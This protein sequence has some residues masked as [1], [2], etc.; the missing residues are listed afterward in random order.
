MQ[1]LKAAEAR[2]Q[3]DKIVQNDPI[4][5]SKF[6][7]DNT[8]SETTKNIYILLFAFPI[9]LLLSL[10]FYMIASLDG[11]MF[12]TPDGEIDTLIS[13]K[14]KDI[15]MQVDKETGG[16]LT[17]RVSDTFDK[18]ALGMKVV[19][20]MD[21]QIYLLQKMT[22]VGGPESNYNGFESNVN[23][24]WDALG[25]YSNYP[26]F[27]EWQSTS[28]MTFPVFKFNEENVPVGD[29]AK[30]CMGLSW[31]PI[32]KRNQ[33]DKYLDVKG[34]NEC[35]MHASGRANWEDDF[36]INGLNFKIWN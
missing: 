29:S 35:E 12:G 13:N 28:T 23:Y 8:N 26:Y 31:V 20:S 27:Y 5:L 7:P 3:F 32:K 22:L 33:Y 6:A 16:E 19:P 10:L 4:K 17:G 2:Q 36:P 30:L 15:I 21:N 11:A 9:L 34:F 1:N 14:M 24:N 18:I 25:D